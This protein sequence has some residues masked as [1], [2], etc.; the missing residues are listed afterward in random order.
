MQ[1]PGPLHCG[2]LRLGLL[3]GYYILYSFCRA[4]EDCTILLLTILRTMMTCIVTQRNRPVGG[5]GGKGEERERKKEKKPKE[6][7]T[8]HIQ[9]FIVL[10]HYINKG[11]IILMIVKQG[12]FCQEQRRSSNYNRD[13]LYMAQYPKKP[14]SMG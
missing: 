1:V 5:G 7:H 6:V 8:I 4:T 3:S 9:Q 2:N 12:Q 11:I 13:Q 10:H 14:R